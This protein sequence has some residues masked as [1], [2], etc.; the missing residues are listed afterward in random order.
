MA[1]LEQFSD[2]RVERYWQLIGIINGWPVQPSR[3]PAYEWFMRALRAQAGPAGGGGGGG[4]VASRSV[5]Q[6]SL[7]L[8]AGERLHVVWDWNGTL[9]DDAS[10]VIEATRAAFAA[11]G[12]PVAVTAELYRRHFTRPIPLF[13]ERLLGR[14]ISAEEWPELDRAFHHRY[15][16]LHERCTL[17]EGAREVL[18]EIDSRGWTQ[19]LCSMLPHQYLEPAVRQHGIREHFVRIDGLRRGERGGAKLAH[20][21]E[22]LAQLDTPPSRTVLVGDTVDDALAARG[23]GIACVL[24][25][26][27]AGLHEPGAVVETGAP[28]AANLQEALAFL[29]DGAA[30]YA[31]AA[32]TRLSN[33][34]L[35]R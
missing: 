2:Q 13:Y 8:R 27:G 17:A 7:G 10:T 16:R 3:A 28:V 19:S 30:A 22:H 15:G 5:L 35:E 23:A 34:G 29:A 33:L 4:R 14:A 20:L 1:Q 24:V 31:S 11:A 25:D 12:I 26:S 32:S 6:S 9:L 18:G 21:T